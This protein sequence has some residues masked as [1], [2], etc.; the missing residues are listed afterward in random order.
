MRKEQEEAERLHRTAE[1]QKQAFF[2]SEQD[3]KQHA[4]RLKDL[5]S[6]DLVR[7][8]PAKLLAKLRSDVQQA[9]LLCDE[10]LEKEIREK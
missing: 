4:M 9:R 2:R 8:E 7:Q 1:E 5:E 10:K 6:S 3:V